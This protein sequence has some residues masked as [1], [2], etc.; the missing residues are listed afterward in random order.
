MLSI[1]FERVRKESDLPKFSSS[2]RVESSQGER[3]EPPTIP[4]QGIDIE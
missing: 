1:F 3:P 4:R 2:D